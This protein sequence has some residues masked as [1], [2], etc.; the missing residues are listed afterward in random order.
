[1]TEETKETPA[2]ETVIEEKKEEKKEWIPKTKLGKEILKGKY[3][4]I[5]DVLK[6]G[7]LI[8]EPGIVDYL[9]PELKHE[10]IYIGGSPGKGG[11]IRRTATRRTVRM[12]KSGRRFKL[13][14]LVVVGNENGVVG[15]GKASS[16]EHRLAIEKAIEQAKL[17]VILV[18]R[19]CGSWECGCGLE[20]SIPFRTEGKCGSVRV[21][22]YPAPVG[23]GIVANEPSKQILSLAGV[24]DIW[25]KVFGQTE[26]RINLIYAIFDALKN[27]S[28][29][30]GDL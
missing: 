3:K 29:V 6:S 28:R 11:G 21:T 22:L 24:K 8:L 15:V 7:E 26:T 19:G 4:S 1:M 23:V 17:N 30:K 13:T 16:N 10:I 27:L 18:K 12:H 5:E 2:E 14:S 25:V 9:V 20:H